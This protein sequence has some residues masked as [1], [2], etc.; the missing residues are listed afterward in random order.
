MRAWAIVAGWI[1]ACIPAFAACG[2]APALM[3]DQGLHRQ[4]RIDRDCAHPEHP[5]VLVE[6]P[7]SDT[8][9]GSSRT[10]GASGQRENA[11]IRPGARVVVIGPGTLSGIRMTGVALQAGREGAAILI[12]SGLSGA[13]LRGVV[14][15]PAL[16]ELLPAK[17]WN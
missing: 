1:M 6:V 3:V 14:R 12:R 10:P 11:E 9:T 7:W 4:W 2:P 13:T 8:A 16:V 17:G 5:A 15:G